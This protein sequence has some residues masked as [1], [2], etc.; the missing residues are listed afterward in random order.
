MKFK[1]G[2]IKKSLAV[3]FVSSLITLP[4]ISCSYYDKPGSSVIDVPSKDFN[5]TNGTSK[6]SVV[7]NDIRESAII[8]QSSITTESNKTYVQNI[9]D[10]LENND[11]SSYQ[12]DIS[13]ISS[14][15]N[16]L[17]F[18]LSK[19][20]SNLII[21]QANTILEIDNSKTTN[22]LKF[23]DTISF[24]T[25]IVI[26]SLIS[27]TISI[28]N[29]DIFLKQ[30]EE[31]NFKF[32]VNNQTIKPSINKYLDGMYLGWKIDSVNLFVNEKEYLLENFSFLNNFF[33]H[34]FKYKFDF[35][36][37]GYTY[38]DLENKYEQ[39]TYQV[40]SNNDLD[41]LI[42]QKMDSDITSYFRYGGYG[43]EI[44]NVLQNDLPIDTL[45]KKISNILI[46]I[47]YDENFISLN[48]QKFLKE[49]LYGSVDS[50]DTISDKPFIN[51]F[52]DNRTAI[53][54]LLKEF[55]GSIFQIVSPI[56]DNFKPNLTV[57]SNEYKTIL[58]YISG[59]PQEV[60]TLITGDF[61]GVTSTAKSL[62]NIIFDNYELIFKLLPSNNTITGIQTLLSIVLSKKSDGSKYN[63][64][65]DSIFAST[66]TKQNFINVIKNLVTFS[67]EIDNILKI[68]I[69]DNDSLNKQNLM[70][71]ISALYNFTNTIFEE[72]Q[73]YTDI[74]NKY[75]NLTI[76]KTIVKSPSIN[77]TNKTLTFEYKYNVS[78]KTEAVLDV[79]KI[80]DLISD[81]AF[82]E[83][84]KYIASLNNIDINS[85]A[86][87]AKTSLKKYVLNFIPDKIY[88][89]KND[90][91]GV[92]S[93]NNLTFTFSANG[94]KT[95]FEPVKDGTNYYGGL[96]FSYNMNIFY[97]DPVMFN[98][99]TNNYNIGKNTNKLLIVNADFYYSDFWRALLENVL[100]RDYDVV[101]KAT[102]KT[103]QLVANTSSYND[104]Q[105][106]QNR[107]FVNNV[108]SKDIASFISE[109]LT[110]DAS[111]YVEVDSNIM[112]NRTYQWSDD[113]T[114]EKFT[115]KK[116]Y[117]DESNFKT[118]SNK[119]FTFNN[120]ENYYNLS[121][122]TLFNTDIPLRIF[123]GK[124][125]VI[126]S[127]ININ[128]KISLTLTN[129]NLYF[130]FKV[131]DTTSNKLTN[132]VIK[133][134]GNLKVSTS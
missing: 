41:N 15:V 96:G 55:V 16:L 84:V 8:D 43:N 40:A 6:D 1:K 47:L 48:M 17:F 10:F 5:N 26:R 57:E 107:S 42:S 7:S 85:L 132:S 101:F 87:L 64:L 27:Q 95:W 81:S 133:T 60:Q 18:R 76:T 59:L 83:L 11:F 86:S 35:L 56:L 45:L 28:G 78:L 113:Q 58:S 12:G 134:I 91:N 14:D 34:T 121:I 29:Q 117:I 120:L 100:G 70:S 19:N 90:S 79:S 115:G 88:F 110:K 127:D 39:Q 80:K 49:A 102:L 66:E 108:N 50:D 52:N 54:E 73:T 2:I 106:Y 68:I 98:T 89:G 125:F 67:P 25:T 103:N 31:Y 118:I 62:W 109:T 74:T 4:A 37:E 123:I 9:S 24:R 131:L 71:A 3:L 72:N 46:R 61:L 114:T 105:I 65:Y 129:V 36:I 63:S 99:I 116:P 32:I 38:F 20:Y 94:A 30:D 13:G 122:N 111:N 130:P 128:I 119:L 93:P 44:L 112:H 22:V 97:D 104:S 77:K 82:F 23:G 124:S 53:D 92:S 51:V 33:S 69:I 126:T 21:N 75:K